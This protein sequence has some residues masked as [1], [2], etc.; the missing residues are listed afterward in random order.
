MIVFPLAWGFLPWLC[1][2]AGLWPTS[3]K[4]RPKW[5]ESDEGSTIQA[6]R[7]PFVPEYTWSLNAASM[8]RFLF[9]SQHAPLWRIS[10]CENDLH[11]IYSWII[12]FLNDRFFS[13]VIG[14]LSLVGHDLQI[15]KST[16]L[17]HQSHWSFTLPGER[18]RFCHLRSAQIYCWLNPPQF[19]SKPLRQ[20]KEYFEFVRDKKG[21]VRCG[22]YIE[23]SCLI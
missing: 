15:V 6:T 18:S 16:Q 19:K 3:R 13:Q 7:A 14:I 2:P 4:Q 9:L 22:V 12:L 23:M 1:S 20:R 17:C 10:L 5:P 8:F 21:H 11:A